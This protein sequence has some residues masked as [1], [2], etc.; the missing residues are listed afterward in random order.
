MSDESKKLQVGIKRNDLEQERRRHHLSNV[1]GYH[2]RQSEFNKLF[3]RKKI[4][5][6]YP[7][8]K[9]F[10]ILTNRAETVAYLKSIDRNLINS[11]DTSMN[12]SGVESTDLATICLL[13]GFMLDDR[14]RSSFLEVII[15]PKGSDSRSLWDEVEFDRMIIKQRRPDFNSGRFLSRSSNIVNRAAIEDILNATV[16]FFGNNRLIQLNNLSAVIVEIAENTVF[17]ADPRKGKKLPWIFNTHST[18]G[19][20]WKEIEYC[21]VDQ[22]IGMYTS[23]KKNVNKWNTFSAKIK[24]RLTVAL[25]NSTTQSGFLTKNIPN[26]IGSSTN[27]LE[28]GK[29]VQFVFS[30]AQQEMYQEF[31]IITNKAHVKLKDMQHPIKDI[32]HNLEATV[33]YWKI[34]FY[35]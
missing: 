10:S 23:I 30:R 27:Q 5:A 18:Q 22:G 20:G 16:E 7:G 8:P 11:I 26:G 34:R 15:P 17:H 24:H 33:Y 28:R 31:D 6:D 29:G 4:Y 21:I 14:T 2:V 32:D 35:D 25:D 12:L 3:R 19:D 13:S 9:I 1:R